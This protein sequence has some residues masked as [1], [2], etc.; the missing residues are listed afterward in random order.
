MATKR[1][2]AHEKLNLWP[3]GS[4]YY[5]SNAGRKTRQS[6]SD[7]LQEVEA[8]STDVQVWS[9]YISKDFV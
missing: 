9:H 3:R 1:Q 8:K 7:F 6:A 5:G 4:F 2:C